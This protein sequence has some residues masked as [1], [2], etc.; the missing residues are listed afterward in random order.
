MPRTLII[1]RMAP[2]SEQEVAAVFA[3]SDATSLPH[4]IGVRERSLFT[5]HGLYAHLID[6]DQD[7][8]LAMQTAQQLQAFRSIS[9]ELSPHVAAYDPQTWRSPQDAMARCF[10]HWSARPGAPSSGPPPSPATT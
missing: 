2:E 4:E 8:G 9:E 6:F 7:I 1:A 10:Y 5:F 3:R